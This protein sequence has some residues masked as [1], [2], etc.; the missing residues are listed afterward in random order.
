[1]PVDPAGDQ[2]GLVTSFLFGR[3]KLENKINNK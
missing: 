1:M 2:G 3:N